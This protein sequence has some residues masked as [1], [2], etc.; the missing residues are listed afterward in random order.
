[1]DGEALAYVATASQPRLSRALWQRAQRL[2]RDTL[3]SATVCSALGLLA[4]AYL[5]RADLVA[6]IYLVGVLAVASAL[7]LTE[8]LVA[9]VFHAAVFDY[10]FL[11]PHFVFSW[12]DHEGAIILAA[13]IVLSGALGSSHGRIRAQE[14][15]ALF[16]AQV[17]STMYQLSRELGRSSSFEQVASVTARNVERML[18][19]RAWVIAVGG[20]GPSEEQTRALPKYAAAI[21]RAWAG[22]ETLIEP[23]SPA[24]AVICVPLIATRQAIGVLVVE[25]GNHSSLAERELVMLLEQCAQQAAAAL[26]KVALE[27]ETR[28]AELACESERLRNSLLSAVSHDV[29]T[30][31]SAIRAAGEMLCSERSLD[32]SSRA[33]ELAGTVVRESDRMLRLV[34]NILS[35]TRVESG[36]LALRIEEVAIEDLVDAALRQLAVESLERRVELRLAEDLP[37]AS[38]D[39]ILMSQVLVNLVDNACKYSAPGSAIEISAERTAR[40][41]EVRVADGGPGFQCD[42]ESRLGQKFVRGSA[43]S[44]GPHGLGLGLAICRAIVTAHGGSLRLANRAND[45]GAQVTIHVPESRH[46]RS[47][48]ALLEDA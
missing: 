11:P 35:L 31:L 33:R 44:S 46:E 14:R 12:P 32:A 38:V 45:A 18:Q 25:S 23:A 5:Q 28:R 19:G 6:L 30:P 4:K 40:G 9:G 2:A 34:E 36:S 43:A 37:F 26:E 48:A 20:D 1:V 39:P 8:A 10:V 24:L 17:A 7:P 16:R 27:Q 22:L 21:R 13:I 42:E 29:R 47:A 15:Q 3:V 41:I